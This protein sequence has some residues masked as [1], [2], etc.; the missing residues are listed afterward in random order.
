MLKYLASPYKVKNKI[1]DLLAEFSVLK[2]AEVSDYHKTFP[3]Y[4]ETPL[5]FLPELAAYLGIKAVYIKDEAHRFGLN[6]FKVLGASYA[7]ARY[8]AEQED[9]DVHALS[10]D[11]I[12]ATDLPKTTFTSTTDGNH[13]FGVA[14]TAKLLGQAAVINMPKGT[15]RQRVAAIES[16][17]AQ[18]HVTDMNY[19]DTVRLTAEQARQHGRVIVQDTAW[20]GYED[21]PRWIMKGY[22]T[23]AIETCE[24]L[25][26]PPTH[27][28]VQAGVGAMAA[29]VIASFVN[30]Y[31]ERT[32]FFA[33]MEARQADCFYRSAQDATKDPVAVTGD[34]ATIMAGLACGEASSLAW[35]LIRNHTDGYFS[36]A[37]EVTANGMR[38]LSSPLG[39]DPRIIS[40]ESGAVG[41]GL[42]YILKDYRSIAT[43]MGLSKDSVVLLFSTEGATDREN[44][45]KV[46]WHGK[47]PYCRGE[48]L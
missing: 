29:A 31:A 35:P 33:L 38:L 15:V 3:Q 24:R 42:L 16:L 47:Y 46:V 48:T 20:Q 26:E 25:P 19:D 30:Y 28:F 39:D 27:L 22:S 43:Q 23:M 2:M 18:V 13:G 6:A 5:H 4:M 44:Y 40:G 12:M 45:K 11:K 21:I 37:D 8:I 7:I 1:A 32:P 36:L 17:G 14:W 41:A 34:L 10:Y 9:L